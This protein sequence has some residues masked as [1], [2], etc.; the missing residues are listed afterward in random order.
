MFA[1]FNMSQI[2]KD[3]FIR[4]E[5]LAFLSSSQC[6]Y[7]ETVLKDVVTSRYPKSFGDYNNPFPCEQHK[8]TKEEL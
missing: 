3:N 1:E 7:P 5:R 2:A 4:Q 8:S 6:L